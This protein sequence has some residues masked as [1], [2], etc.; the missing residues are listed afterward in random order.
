M[1]ELSDPERGRYTGPRLH[2]SAPSPY[3]GEYTAEFIIFLT[4]YFQLSHRVDLQQSCNGW[5]MLSTPANK[6]T[7]DVGDEGGQEGGH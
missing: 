5:A 3:K 4:N 7:G 2:N 6:D 1:T